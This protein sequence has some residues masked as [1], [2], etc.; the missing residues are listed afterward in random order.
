MI[1]VETTQTKHQR[2]VGLCFHYTCLKLSNSQRLVYIDNY[3]KLDMYC[4]VQKGL[5]VCLLAL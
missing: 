5:T 3:F 1:C 2:A 4:G